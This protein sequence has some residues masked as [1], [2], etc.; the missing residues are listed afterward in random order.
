MP[1]RPIRK[2][3]E[4]VEN[5]Q[6]SRLKQRLN[7]EDEFGRALTGRQLMYMLEAMNPEWLDLPLAVQ[8][9]GFYRKVIKVEH[10]NIAPTGRKYEVLHLVQGDVAR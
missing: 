9:P 5:E 10:A 1:R 3:V 6:R 2:Q 4:A 8:R 7:V